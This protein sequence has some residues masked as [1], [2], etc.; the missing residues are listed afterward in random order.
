MK[1]GKK[2]YNQNLSKNRAKSVFELLIAAGI[3]K[4]RLSFTGGGEYKSV[5]EKGRQ[6]ARKVTF[7]IN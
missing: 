6:F 1:L 3:S 4:S 5:T 2:N 7:Q